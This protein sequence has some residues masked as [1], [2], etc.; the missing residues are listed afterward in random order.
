MKGDRISHA[1]EKTDKLEGWERIV[2]TLFGCPLSQTGGSEFL[3][4]VF[5][6]A[7]SLTYLHSI[8]FSESCALDVFEYTYKN[9]EI[10]FD[11]DK[12]IIR[13]FRQPTTA[14]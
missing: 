5:S 6:S 10:H 7:L 12:S 3:R 9:E 11:Y 1:R 13:T 14:L 2:G 8:Q 4:R